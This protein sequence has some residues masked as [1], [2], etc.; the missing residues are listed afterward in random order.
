[1]HQRRVVGYMQSVEKCIFQSVRCVPP[2][3]VSAPNQS[4]LTK[5]RHLT[6]V[7]LAKSLQNMGKPCQADTEGCD[8]QVYR[9]GFSVRPEKDADK[10]TPRQQKVGMVLENEERPP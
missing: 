2:P 3:M 5:P 9:M 8:V 6:G 1:M 4:P 10:H 7:E